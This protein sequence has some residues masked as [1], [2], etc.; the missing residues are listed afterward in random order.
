MLVLS[1]L[2]TTAPVAQSN[3]PNAT[4]SLSM[5]PDD[6]PVMD[7]GAAM[8]FAPD[9]WRAAWCAWLRWESGGWMAWRR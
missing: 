7:D 9:D 6:D 4:P 3:A 2:L 5:Y 1:V 8:A